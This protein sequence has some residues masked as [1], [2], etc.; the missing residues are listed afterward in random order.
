MRT[1]LLFLVLA[2][3]SFT[4]CTSEN[5]TSPCKDNPCNLPGKNKCVENGSD[6]TCECNDGF[7]PSGAICIQT[8]ACSPVN[9]CTEINKTKCTVSGDSYTCEC[10][11]G[12]ILDGGVCKINQT[13]C[14]PN[15]CLEENKN[16]CD[17]YNGQVICKCNTGY[18]LV[19]G[20]C[21][22]ENYDNPCLPVNPCTQANKTSCG[23]L[24][25]TTYAC[26][27]SPGYM[28]SG[29][30]CV[31]GTWGNIYDGLGTSADS[32]LITKLY[33]IV[34]DHTSVSYNRTKDIVPDLD[35]YK[36][37]YS[38][39]SMSSSD[40]NVEH[41][42]PQSY[43]AEMSPMVSDLHHLFAVDKI[44]NSKRGNIH[45]GDVVKTDC[46]C[47]TPE[48]PWYCDWIGDGSGAMKGKP[49]TNCGDYSIFQPFADTRGDVARALFYFAV[50]YK[51][52][53]INLSQAGG[54]GPHPY[55]H[56]PPYEERVL[57]LWSLI[58]PV[59]ETEMRRNNEIEDIQHN[60]NPFID[61]PDLIQ[62][63]KDF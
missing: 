24:T 11:T 1:I 50:R 37:K 56:I 13:S 30:N 45:F 7:V 46:P 42:W 9:P 19:N 21:V 14:S 22:D 2:T 12:F 8:T 58:D 20:A 34:K 28:P 44:I 48:E 27:C 38:G 55:N 39:A 62:R 61:R 3:L 32:E 16:V 47:E 49:S 57:K 36:C 54:T 35:S 41:I 59:D 18:K 23:K 51:D 53:Q 43:F 63:I 26:Y 6:F 17:M 33:N 31:A 15:P 52:E 40:L 5:K 25:A 4:A 60:R 29:D 10:D